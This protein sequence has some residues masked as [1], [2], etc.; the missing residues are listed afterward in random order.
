M[1]STL[2]LP[3]EEC[4]DEFT[5][6]RALLHYEKVYLKHPQD[7]DFVPG[8]D[9]M[10]IVSNLPGIGMFGGGF[11]KPLG[12]EKD[13]DIK[14]EK[15]LQIFKPAIKE[16]SLIIMDLPADLYHQQVNVLFY[17]IPDEHRAVYW[18]YRNMLASEDFINA[19]SKGISSVA[20]NDNLF[21]DLAPVGTDDT[22]AHTDERLNNKIPYLGQIESEEEKIIL[23]RM[24]HA[25][26][27]SI[28]RNLMVCHT[29]DLVPFTTNIGYSSVLNQMQCNWSK[30]I[31]AAN[32][33]SVELT[34]LDLVGKI[35]NLVF[36]DFLDK[37]KIDALSINQIL[38]KRTK[39]WGDYCL[40]KSYLE[41]TLLKI[42]LDSKDQ[43]EFEKK[44][45]D[46]FTKFLKDNRDYVHERGNLGFKIACNIGTIATA[47][48]MGP[49]LLQSFI[50]ASSLGL[51]MMLACPAAFLIAEKRIPEIRNVLKQNHELKR[52]PIYDLYNYYKPL[53]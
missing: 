22:V 49:A 34:D 4:V 8:N 18:N 41:E 43:K 29:K 35:E 11:A 51:L 9:L 23:T 6:K 17:G 39:M 38:D 31:E 30:I 26:I 40:N 16:G 7:R 15:L 32:D 44:V 14:F 13:H 50:T 42:A 1:R 52:L 47:S 19:A 3:T 46:L 10:S 20:L 53:L 48:T 28:S 12:K 45:A 25:R 21:D 5:L 36:S 24:V 33:G 37:A 27:A 2:V